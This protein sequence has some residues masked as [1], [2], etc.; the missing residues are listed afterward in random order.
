M[1][2]FENLDL[3]EKIELAKKI[4]KPFVRFYKRRKPILSSEWNF[5]IRTFETKRRHK[6]KVNLYNGEKIVDVLSFNS[7]V[8]NYSFN[9]SIKLDDNKIIGNYFFTSVG[10]VNEDTYYEAED[11]LENKVNYIKNK[12]LKINR[13]YLSNKG[14]KLLYIGSIDLKLL[15]KEDDILYKE[16]FKSHKY[17]YN[18]NEERQLINIRDIKILKELETNIKKIDVDLIELKHKNE[19]TS[20]KKDIIMYKNITKKDK[21]ISFINIENTYFGIYIPTYYIDREEL[22]KFMNSKRKFYELV[23]K[24]SS[25]MKN[26][27]KLISESYTDN[28]KGSFKMR[29][30]EDRRGKRYSEKEYV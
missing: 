18:E 14:D 26:R 29:I 16:E 5:K 12:D 28:K 7:Y 25:I 15:I 1:N 4:T 2:I 11:I 6:K 9:S 20:M 10:L 13:F 22:L 19:I 23:R 27:D 17:F 21:C 8:E 24:P 30:Y 3:F